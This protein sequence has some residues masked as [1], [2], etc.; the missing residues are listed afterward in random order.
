MSKIKYVS[1]NGD[2]VLYESIFEVDDESVEGCIDAEFETVKREYIKNCDDYDYADYPS[3]DGKLCTKIWNTNGD[4][5]M[6]T[7]L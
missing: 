1:G 5:V 3:D 4:W 2:D 7:E 6:W